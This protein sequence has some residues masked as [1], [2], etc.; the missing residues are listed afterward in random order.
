[1]S[2]EKLALLLILFF[3]LLQ[4]VHLDPSIYLMNEENKGSLGL[5]LSKKGSDY[6]Q[7]NPETTPSMPKKQNKGY[8]FIEIKEICSIIFKNWGDN[9]VH[10]IERKDFL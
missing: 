3:S 10:F 9:L 4:G 7:N 8:I 1:M 2:F 6:S 5:L